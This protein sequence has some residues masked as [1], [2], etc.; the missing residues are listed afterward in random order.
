MVSV[1]VFSVNLDAVRF[2]TYCLVKLIFGEYFRY[3]SA[4]HV[5]DL[6]QLHFQLDSIRVLV[7]ELI[8]F[9]FFFFFGR[10]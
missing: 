4:N 5:T 8:F 6:L 2:D 9:F 7:R 10:I 3:F 1:I